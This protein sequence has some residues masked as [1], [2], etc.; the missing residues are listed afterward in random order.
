MTLEKLAQLA[1]VS[2]GTVSKAFSGSKEISEKTKQKIFDIA[3]QHGCYNKYMKVDF[4]KKVVAVILPE[5]KS[6]YYVDIAV[7]LEEALKNSGFLSVFCSS[8]FSEKN[9]VDFI[10]YFSVKKNCDGIIM[11]NSHSVIPKDLS[12]PV[13]VIGG[14]KQNQ[15]VDCISIDFLSGLDKAIRHLK[16]NGHTK[17]AFLS[18]NFTKAYKNRIINVHPSLIPSFC[19]VGYY[20]LKVHE[21]ALK[22]G[23][24]VTGATVHFVNEIPD[25]GKIIMQKAVNVLEKDT[26]ETLQKRVMKMAEWKILPASA[27]LVSQKILKGEI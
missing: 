7:H 26:P 9:E 2:L 25:G 15:N 13:V 8:N 11:I 27:E 12:V 22:K 10:E 18:E 16:E 23:V 19:G 1:G 24:K 14:K 21:E 20:G 5:I 3:K 17:I 4:D 6:A